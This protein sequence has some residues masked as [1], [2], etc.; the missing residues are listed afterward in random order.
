VWVSQ[1]DGSV[2]YVNPRWTEFTGQSLQ[3]AVGFGWLA[4]LHPDDRERLREFWE[5]CVS[6]GEPFEGE[7][8]YRR[9]D[10]QYLWHH[11][12]T[13]RSFDDKGEIIAWYGASLDIHTQKIAEQ[14]LR[15]SESHFRL[16]ADSAPAM[17]W[18]MDAAGRCS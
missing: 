11:F 10:G 2:D 9:H 7:A 16:L 14:A 3:E 17:L 6:S 15:D 12:K 1:P 8:R 5:H 18:L 4:T 13:V